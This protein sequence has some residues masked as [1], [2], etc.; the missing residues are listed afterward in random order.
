MTY[1]DL[2][3]L[4]KINRLPPE[5]LPTRTAPK[6][7]T[8]GGGEA[9]GSSQMLVFMRHEHDIHSTIAKRSSCSEFWTDSQI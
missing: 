4:N 9:G 3:K 6:N 5:S 8:R 2:T 1:F 7:I